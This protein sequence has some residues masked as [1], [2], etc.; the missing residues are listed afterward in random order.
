MKFLRFATLIPLMLVGVVS[1]QS[2]ASSQT[3]GRRLEVMFFGAPT[4][5]QTAHDPVTRFRVLKKALDVDGIDLTYIQDPAEALN[6]TT[7]ANYDAVLMYGNWN[8]SGPMPPD[9]LQA[10]LHYVD[11]GGGFLPI[12][13]ASACYGGSPEF[14]KLVGAHFKKHGDGVFKVTNVNPQHPIMKGYE[15]FEAWDE[16]RVHDR[17]ADDRVIL[18]KHDQEPWTWVRQQG[19][20]RVFYTSA[21]HDHRVWDLPEFQDLLKR[22]IFWSVGPERAKLFE[23]LKLPKKPGGNP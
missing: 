17:P 16:T 6:A 23:A 5:N 11:N 15:G 10:L 9:Q 13:C 7:L 18:E 21:G 19:K 2:D 20:G 8:A 12:H 3:H 4:A 1:A 14:V 22:A